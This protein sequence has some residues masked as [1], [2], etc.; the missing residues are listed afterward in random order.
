LDQDTIRHALKTAR[1]FGFRQVKIKHEDSSFSAI[2]GEWQHEEEETGFEEFAVVD[3]SPTEVSVTSP[4]VGYFQAL[5]KPLRVGDA[6]TKGQVI[7]EVMALGL[8]NDIVAKEG[9]EVAELLVKNG[10]PLQYGAEII[11]LKV[12]L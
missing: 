7:G 2:L 10:D 11:R 3:A 5:P 1:E 12:A 9:G 6:V 4:A 8:G